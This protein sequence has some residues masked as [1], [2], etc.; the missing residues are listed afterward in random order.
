[1]IFTKPWFWISLVAILAVGFVLLCW[2]LGRNAIHP[3]E[4]S[5]EYNESFPVIVLDE[6]H[7]Q[8]REGTK[9]YEVPQGEGFTVDVSHLHELSDKKE[10]DGMEI[11]I[12]YGVQAVSNFPIIEGQSHY[13][14]APNRG[15]THGQE[16]VVGI[17]HP[18][19]GE[20]NSFTPAWAGIVKI[21]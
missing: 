1:M 17:G 11:Q 3:K 16:I 6:Q 9:T 2:S 15:L 20:K 13:S 5:W 10:A 18:N 4:E 8:L 7:S 14:F 19:P 21:E 12:I